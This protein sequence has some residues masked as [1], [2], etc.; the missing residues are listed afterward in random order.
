MHLGHALSTGSHALRA[1]RVLAFGLIPHQTCVPLA[2][3]PRRHGDPQCRT[4]RPHLPTPELV[5]R[6]SI[7]VSLNGNRPR[8]QGCKF[9]GQ[10]RL[11][12]RSVDLAPTGRI[13][14]VVDQ[15]I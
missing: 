2:K 1:T 11:L 15:I 6:R 5:T 14:P 4:L 8:G 12:P 7:Y 9:T 13:G 10:A 3:R